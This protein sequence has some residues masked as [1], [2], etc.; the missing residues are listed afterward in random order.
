MTAYDV[1]QRL[2]AL[3]IF[4]LDRLSESSTYQGLAFLGMFLGAKYVSD[5]PWTD[6]ATLA[7]ATALGALVSAAL[8]ILLPDSW[9]KEP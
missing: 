9:R 7:G 4:L 8:K 1:R 6:P 5:A 3:G 2:R